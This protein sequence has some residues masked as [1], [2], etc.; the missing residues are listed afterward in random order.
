M[1]STRQ[2]LLFSR[3][4]QRISNAAEAIMRHENIETLMSMQGGKTGRS[5]WQSGR[6][7]K[8][9][10]PIEMGWSLGCKNN[11]YIRDRRLVNPYL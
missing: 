1:P 11:R 8:R 5:S 7:M 3:N 9:C 6:N 4:Q 2:P 10:I